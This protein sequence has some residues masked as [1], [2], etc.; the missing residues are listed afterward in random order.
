MYKLNMWMCLFLYSV[1][2]SWIIHKSL[3]PIQIWF[4]HRTLHTFHFYLKPKLDTSTKY[5]LYYLYFILDRTAFNIFLFFLFQFYFDCVTY[6]K[7][8]SIDI[9]INDKLTYFFPYFIVVSSS[10]SNWKREHTIS[11]INIPRC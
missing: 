8:S 10:N 7:Q 5:D 11:G 1:K 9:I 4:F 6:F 2:L 3:L